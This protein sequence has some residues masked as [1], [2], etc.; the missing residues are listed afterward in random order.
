M[1]PAAPWEMS[2]G[3]VEVNIE[4]G[5]DVDRVLDE[6]VQ[7]VQGAAVRYQTGIMIARNGPGS[8]IVRAHPAVPF[9]LIRQH[10]G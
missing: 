9:G 2:P 5:D 4:G 8:Y 10:P 1:S 7:A 6:A 3:L